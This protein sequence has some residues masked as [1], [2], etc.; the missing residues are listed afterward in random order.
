MT[1][2]VIVRFVVLLFAL[3]QAVGFDLLGL[4][5][6]ALRTQTGR[7]LVVARSGFSVR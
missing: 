2:L 1:G 3:G 7:W 6:D 5:A 4:F